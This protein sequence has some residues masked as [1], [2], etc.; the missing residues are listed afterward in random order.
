MHIVKSSNL[1][2]EDGNGHEDTA[3]AYVRAESFPYSRTLPED[4][5]DT[6]LVSVHDSRCEMMDVC[7]RANQEQEDEEERS[8][9]EESGH[10][11]CVLE[12]LADN[13]TRDGY[14]SRRKLRWL[15]GCDIGL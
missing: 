12:E 1:V 8:E 5:H 2:H 4:A 13:R 7:A 15:Q 10:G 3:Y 6:V 11:C 9:V 14:Q